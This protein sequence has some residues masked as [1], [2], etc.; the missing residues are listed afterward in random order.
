MVYVQNE[1]SYYIAQSDLWWQNQYNNLYEERWIIMTCDEWIY[2]NEITLDLDL[3]QCSD[4]DY[5]M[6][7]YMTGTEE[8]WAR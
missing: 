7:K 5:K 2:D 1:R 8:Y 3:C 6:I 4:H